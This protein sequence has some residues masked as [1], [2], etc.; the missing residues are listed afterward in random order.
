MERFDTYRK[1]FHALF[2]YVILMSFLPV[3]SVWAE[4]PASS[5]SAPVINTFAPGADNLGALNNSVNLFTGDVALPMNLFSLPGLNVNVALSYSSN[6]KQSVDIWN[7]EAPTG[8]L[9]LGWSM[10]N[11]MILVDEKGTGSPHDND[12]YLA[13]GG[14]TTLLIR[15]GVKGSARVYETKNYQFWEIL[16]YPGD[17]RWEITKE[18]GSK[19]TYGGGLTQASDGN[20]TCN[21][22][23]V[24]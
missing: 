13:A 14:V 1:Y 23:S 11:D 6:V 2:L 19:S 5:T 10:G 24:Q 18:D 9:G 17:E 22:N 4:D 15:T 7:Q 3:C 21:G 16:Y 12:Y 8:I 20:K